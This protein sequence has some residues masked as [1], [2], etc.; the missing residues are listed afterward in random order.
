MKIIL[1][2]LNIFWTSQHF[3]CFIKTIFLFYQQMVWISSRRCKFLFHNF[4]IFTFCCRHYP[5]RCSKCTCF[6]IWM[7]VTQNQVITCT[8]WFQ[9]KK[10]TKHQPTNPIIPQYSRES[11]FYLAC[12]IIL[13]QREVAADVGA[14][15]TGH[16]HL[17]VVPRPAL[18]FILASH[19]PQ[20]NSLIGQLCFSLFHCV[21]LEL[22]T[23]LPSLLPFPTFT[24]QTRECAVLML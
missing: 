18:M 8:T 6:N 17:E 24:S 21:C 16:Q 4:G 20:I 5:S 1:Q 13:L 19:F 7:H 12:H 22:V 14:N 23:F 11:L 3:G 10:K 9:L 15:G 2:H